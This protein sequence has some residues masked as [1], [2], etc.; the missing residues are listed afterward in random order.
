MKIAYLSYL[1]FFGIIYTSFLRPNHEST[2]FIQEN[3][4]DSKCAAQT[5]LFIL[6]MSYMFLTKHVNKPTAEC[7]HWLC[8]FSSEALYRNRSKR[9]WNCSTFRLNILLV[10]FSFCAVFA[11]SL[12]KW[13][14][15][16]KLECSFM[17]TEKLSANKCRWCIFQHHRHR[18]HN[19]HVGTRIC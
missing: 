17:F 3:P 15:T 19:I 14:L 2:Q 16:L 6:K 18:I 8:S 11:M 5:F 4:A 12:M 1:T 7:S 13:F 10:M 9:N